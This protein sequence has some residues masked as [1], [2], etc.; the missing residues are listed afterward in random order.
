M[1]RSNSTKWVSAS[2]AGRAAFCPHTLELKQKGAKPSIQAQKAMQL[3][4][5]GHERINKMAT[6]DKRCFI[7]SH[8][9]GV[10]DPRTTLLRRYRDDVLKKTGSGKVFIAVYYK[11]SPG[12][13]AVAK[14][15]SMVD[16]AFRIIVDYLVRCLVEK[17]DRDNV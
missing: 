10:E 6:Q 12:L 5:S 17:M 3:G 13:V 9:Y 11:M 1:S 16:M 4:V 2:E 15:M 14:K 8:L 7:A